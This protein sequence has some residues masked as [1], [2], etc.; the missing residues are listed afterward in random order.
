MRTLAAKTRTIH[1]P[2]PNL[3]KWLFTGIIRPKLVYGAMIWGKAIYKKE[4]K[5]QLNSL[6]RIACTSA[7][8]IGR[9][10][11]VIVHHI[12]ITIT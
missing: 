6:N 9:S 8:V 10:V 12:L 7:T 5:K 11:I 1:G 4:Y 3:M 2:K